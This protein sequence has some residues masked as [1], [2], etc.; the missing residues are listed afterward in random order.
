MNTR[1]HRRLKQYREKR[2][3][4][5]VRSTRNLLHQVACL[6]YTGGSDGPPRGV[7]FTHANM[8][9]AALSVRRHLRALVCTVCPASVCVHDLHVCTNST[10]SPR[11]QKPEYKG[12]MRLHTQ[13]LIYYCECLVLA[14]CVEQA[15]LSARCLCT[16]TGLESKAHLG[17]L[18][19]QSSELFSVRTKFMAAS[20]AV[21]NKSTIMAAQLATNAFNIMANLTN[22]PRFVI[23]KAAS[24]RH[25]KSC[26]DSSSQKL[27]RFVISKAASIRHLKSSRV[28][29]HT[30]FEKTRKERVHDSHVHHAKELSGTC[31]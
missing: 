12:C 27:P 9:A 21:T 15:C 29:I 30:C 20:G 28:R 19:N 26:L 23:S 24:I 5:R 3:P 4:E 17:S 1:A 18:K 16:S 8:I 22:M 7:P 6:L 2:N 14:V 25:L 31:P 10:I 13:D 11:T